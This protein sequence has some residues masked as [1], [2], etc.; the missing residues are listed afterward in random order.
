MTEGALL[1]VDNETLQYE[2][3]YFK[4]ISPKSANEEA[5]Q[6]F[7]GEMQRVFDSSDKKHDGKIDRKEFET[8]IT[9]YFKLKDI[10]STAENFDQYFEK[11]DIAHHHWIMFEDFI[12]FIDQV[13]E[14][15]ILP[16]ITEEM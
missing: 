15:D 4:A 3:E 2:F 6:S 14:G 16:F 9:G 8:L 10:K 7:L 11:L 5:R 1:E 12:K 13:N